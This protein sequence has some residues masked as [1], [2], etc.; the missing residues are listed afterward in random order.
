MRRHVDPTSPEVIADSF[1]YSSA[2]T[3][4]GR[5]V[6]IAKKTISIDL[7]CVANLLDKRNKIFS[8]RREYVTHDSRCH[9]GVTELDQSIHRVLTVRET[10][11]KFHAVIDRLFQKWL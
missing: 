2:K 5:F 6:K 10:V 7:L 11:G 9:S 4:L 1:R 8:Q 3:H